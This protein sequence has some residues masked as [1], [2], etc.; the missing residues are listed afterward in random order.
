MLQLAYIT[1]YSNIYYG[2][3][4][5]QGGFADTPSIINMSS[6]STLELKK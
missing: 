1:K 3:F 6:L 2:S 4:V 5:P